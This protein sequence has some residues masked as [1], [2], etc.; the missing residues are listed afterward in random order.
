MRASYIFRLS[1]FITASAARAGCDREGAA[2][3]SLQGEGITDLRLTETPDGSYSFTGRRG[4][5]S[6]SGTITVDLGLLTNDIR[7]LLQCGVP[8]AGASGGP[9]AGELCKSVYLG[10]GAPKDLPKAAELCAK[11][12]EGG[13]G[14]GC[15]I[16][17]LMHLNGEGVAKDPARALA[18]FVRG[19]SLGY[20]GACANQGVLLRDGLTGPRDPGTAASLFQKACDLGEPEA[21][22]NLGAACYLGDGVPIDYPRA[23]S[24]FGK[25][26][27]AGAGMA[28]GNLALMYDEGKGV[29]RDESRAAAL[30]AKACQ[31]GYQQAC[32]KGN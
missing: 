5:E 18:Y 13:S 2:A 21:C 16:L 3:K 24:L 22:S 25:A 10:Q 26:C 28:C 1:V 4:E 15:Q 31:L 8:A 19:C 14:I 23:L 6:C 30:R 27:E 20:G 11:E 32:G 29:D 9:G 17:G 12:C 7:R